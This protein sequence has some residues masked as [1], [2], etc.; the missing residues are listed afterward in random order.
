MAETAG[1]F[2]E[3]FYDV[4]P[5]LDWDAYRANA[6]LL[7]PAAEEAR[8]R[9][10]LRRVEELFGFELPG[11]I[12]LM[13]SFHTYD[14]F[15]RFERGRHRVYLGVD[16]SH[17]NGK[18]VDILTVHELTHVARETRPEVWHAMGLDP[19]MERETYLE[20]QTT[21]EHL[22]GEGFSCLVSEL[23]VPGEPA[24]AYAYQ[25]AASWRAVQAQAPLIDRIIKR[26][27]RDP[28]GDYGGFYGMSPRYSHY[29]WAWLW[30]RDVLRTVGGG[31]PRRLVG[32]GSPSLFEHALAFEFRP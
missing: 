7:D 19:L 16:E 27:I 11:E 5:A 30:A 18:Y 17:R 10:H 23:L 3:D 13:G 24:W 29:V 20:S 32:L 8:V 9:G 2:F 1:D 12:C 4:L 31:D 28:N 14:G 21:M 15:A 6:M 26:E 25:T 22:F